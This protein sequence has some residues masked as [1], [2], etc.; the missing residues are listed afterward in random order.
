MLHMDDTIAAISTAVGESGIGIV[1]VSGPEAFRIGDRV[2][3][4]ARRNTCLADASSHTVHYGLIKDG[5]ETIDEVL[6]S[7]F[8]SPRSYTTEDTIEINGHGGR[9]A[10]QRIL[11][12]VFK[13]GARPADPGE[14]TRR[15]FL[16]GRIDLSQAEA[17]MDVIGSA[18]E[19]ALKNSVRQLKGDLGKKIRNLRE[20]IL[21]EIAW[22]EASLDDPEH[23]SLEGYSESLKEKNASWN[24]EL[25]EM[26]RTFD[27]GRQVREGIH[28]VI[29][30]K[31]NAGKSTLL[32]LLLRE[33]RAIV[34][35]IAGTTRD[36]VTETCRLGGLTLV[37]SDTA[38]IRQ[39]DDVVEKIGVA[40][41]RKAI[42]E[43][44]LVFFMIDSSSAWDENDRELISHLTDKKVLILW[45]KTDLDPVMTEEELVRIW[46]EAAG[47]SKDPVPPIIRIS[48][49]TGQGAEEIEQAV[50][51]QF[52]HALTGA[53]DD[54]FITNSRHKD[55]LQRALE[56]TEQVLEGISLGLPEDFLSINLTQ[57]CEALGEIT[58][59]TI[60]DDLAD[61]IFSH[62]CMGK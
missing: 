31:P 24:A 1:R 56:E 3:F 57:A 20:T 29:V 11:Q 18:N 40:R 48:A 30:G 21:H 59:E 58:G 16:N 5:D 38:G 15:A 36:V 37:L 9:Y 25:E 45:N 22:I 2:F 23:Y 53:A 10:L 60:R 46:K 39:T 28:T 49:G 6:V 34:T 12:T 61:E 42:E 55:C 4:P 27:Y 50:S 54:T 44:D 62:F 26:I 19:Q 43:A 41:S 33:E 13:N 47:H 35:E 52:S 8:R 51:R 14:F 7:V 17:V 32:N